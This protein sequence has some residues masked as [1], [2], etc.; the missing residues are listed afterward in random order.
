MLTQNPSMKIEYIRGDIVR[1]QK[2]LDMLSDKLLEKV[3]VFCFFMN[4]ITEVI[5]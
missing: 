4:Q 1:Q 3:F 5:G 2:G